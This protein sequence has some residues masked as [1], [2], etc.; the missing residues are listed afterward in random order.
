MIVKALFSFLHFVAVFGIVATIFMEWQTMSRTPTVIEAKRIQ[1]CDRW[2]GIF[3]AWVLIV[4]F[5]RVFYFEKGQSFYF[6]NPFFHAKLGLF[7]VIGLLSIYP[8]IRFLKWRTSLAAGTP[9]A[10]TEQEY[11]WIMLAL[12]AELLLL[13]GMALCAALMARGVGM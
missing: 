2:Y 11:K 5:L 8:T 3:S 4:G 6:A 12:R 9:P 10:V 1:I 13:L 7:V